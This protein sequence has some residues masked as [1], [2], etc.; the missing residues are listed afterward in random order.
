VTRR[1]QGLLLTRIAASAAGCAVGW[2]AIPTLGAVGTVL[3]V[4]AGWTVAL[5]GGAGML[6]AVRHRPPSP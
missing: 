2:L 6:W 4:A 1:P 5:L 3:G